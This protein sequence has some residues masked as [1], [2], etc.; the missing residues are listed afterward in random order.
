MKRALEACERVLGKEHPDTLTSVNNLADLYQAQGRYGEAEPLYKRALEARERVLGKE[1]PDTL[2]SVNNLAALYQAQGRYAEAEP[3]YQ[4]RARR[5]GAGAGQGASRYACKREQSGRCSIRPRAAMAR[6]S[7][8]IRRA[9]EAR[10]R[11]LGKEH[12]DTLASVNNLASLYQAQGRYGEAEPL[13]SARSRP[14]SGCWARSI[15]IRL[16]A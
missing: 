3:L 10:E 7:R 4:A 6:P 13:L 11:V 16:Q 9:L 14:A 2:A 5:P 1:H 15:P 8:S 12:P